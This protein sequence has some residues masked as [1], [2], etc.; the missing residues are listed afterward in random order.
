MKNLVEMIP[1]L[2]KYILC[3]FL[4]SYL[5]PFLIEALANTH[6]GSICHHC[7]VLLSSEPSSGVLFPLSLKMYGSITKIF[8]IKCSY[9]GEKRLFRDEVATSLR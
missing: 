6:L 2:R 3:F 4:N 5:S 9:G 8:L 1:S 7:L